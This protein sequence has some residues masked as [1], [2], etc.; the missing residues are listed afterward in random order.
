MDLWTAEVQTALVN[1][2]VAVLSIVAAWI[3][4]EGAKYVAALKAK[5]MQ[6]A[7][8]TGNDL[9]E[10]AA[11]RAV[12]WV[13]Q[14]AAQQIA[15]WTGPQ[16]LA[17]AAD[18]VTRQLPGVS[19]ADAET[20]IEAV[21]NRLKYGWD[22]ITAT[23]VDDAACVASTITT[24][25]VSEVADKVAAVVASAEEAVAKLQAIKDGETQ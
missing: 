3:G 24:A 2:V 7:I 21:I 16:K 14:L 8:K 10:S 6:A 1:L 13:E 18:Y 17:A 23:D 5:A 4:V 11:E 20:A 9:L 19:E 15:K 25:T 22:S 12:R